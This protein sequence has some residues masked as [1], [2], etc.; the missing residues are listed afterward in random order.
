MVLPSGERVWSNY[1]VSEWASLGLISQI[2]VVQFGLTEL[3]IR[4]A[5]ARDLTNSKR[6]QLRQ[7]IERDFS[8]QFALRFKYMDSIPRSASGKYEDFICL[9]N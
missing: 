4:M 5:V 3:E 9:V 7:K 6:E 2:Q 1:I 8:R